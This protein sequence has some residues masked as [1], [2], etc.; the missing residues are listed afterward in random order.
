MSIATRF[1]RFILAPFWFC[2]VALGVLIGFAVITFGT[3]AMKVKLIRGALAVIDAQL[4]SED[5]W[6][7]CTTREELEQH[8]ESL[9]GFLVMMGEDC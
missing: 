6:S 3:R 5:G 7:V 4:S 2:G 1:W 9:E 8:K